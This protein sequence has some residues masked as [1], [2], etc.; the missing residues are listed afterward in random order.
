MV[1]NYT[2]HYVLEEMSKA[3]DLPNFYKI[4]ADNRDLNYG[5]FQRVNYKF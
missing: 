2:K 3:V 1:K 5:S 4:P